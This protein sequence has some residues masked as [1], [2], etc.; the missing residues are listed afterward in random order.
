MCQPHLLPTCG[1]TSALVSHVGS[2]VS[3]SCPCIELQAVGLLALSSGPVLIDEPAQMA[4]MLKDM[5]KCRLVFGLGGWS[6]SGPRMQHFAISIKL[7]H[8]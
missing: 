3:I 1:T 4:A 7:F 2:E 6:A 5:M 8:K